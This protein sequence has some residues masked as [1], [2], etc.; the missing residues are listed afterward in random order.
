M[1]SC[2]WACGTAAVTVRRRRVRHAP[3]VANEEMK[4]HG[5]GS[6]LADAPAHRQEAGV[7]LQRGRADG[8]AQRA[9]RVWM[10]ALHAGR[11]GPGLEAGRRHMHH[12]VPG[13]RDH[14]LAEARG[15]AQRVFLDQHGVDAWRV[16]G[17]GMAG[18]G[19]LQRRQAQ[20]AQRDRQRR[21]ADAWV[22][23]DVWPEFA[24][25]RRPA[26]PHP[27]ATGCGNDRKPSARPHRRPRTS[28]PRAA[29][30]GRARARSTNA[31][32][33]GNAAPRRPPAPPA[34]RVAPALAD[35]RACRRVR[36]PAAAVAAG[37]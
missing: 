22:I 14:A 5:P 32:D 23:D 36:R 19:E 10:R 6:A 1:L 15:I 16:R 3:A 7:Q 17:R 30:S 18:G 20:I 25:Q 21:Q 29:R 2:T 9:F 28:P 4:L 24:R 34:S 33:T 11:R 35:G 31:C 13:Q 26:P 12:A 37:G 27:A 8:D